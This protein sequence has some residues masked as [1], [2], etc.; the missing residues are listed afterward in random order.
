VTEQELD[1]LSECVASL[2]AWFDAPLERSTDIA[3]RLRQLV[4][5]A[6]APS[7]AIIT[8]LLSDLLGHPVLLVRRTAIAVCEPHL[9]CLE[10]RRR[11][12]LLAWWDP[13]EAGREDA[14]KLLEEHGYT[15]HSMRDAAG[16]R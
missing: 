8:R 12:G 1:N 11:L 4:R 5:L 2:R 14:R 10:L 16:L 15:M 13:G 9:D 3:P 6:D 7:S